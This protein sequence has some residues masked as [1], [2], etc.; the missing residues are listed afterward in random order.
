MS[1]YTIVLFVHVIGAIGYF[2]SIG[3]SLLILVGLLKS[4]AF[5]GSRARFMSSP[6]WMLSHELPSPVI[7][8]KAR[9]WPVS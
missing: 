1:I 9:T 2:L 7:S 4:I 5:L 3:S 8:F 6:S